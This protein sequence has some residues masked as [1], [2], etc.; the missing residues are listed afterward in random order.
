M[1]DEPDV[2][3]LDLP[4]PNDPVAW[5][6][7]TV[8]TE[9][10]GPSGERLGQ[11][12]AMLGT[13][14]EGIFH[15]VAVDPGQGGEPRV[16]SADEVSRLTPARVHVTWSAERLAQAEPWNRRAGEAHVPGLKRPP[17]TRS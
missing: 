12:A 7:V 10:V 16:V 15:G 11:V 2:A 3:E 6:Y 9:V 17:G 4:G 8:G 13:A 1:T 14:E 5:S